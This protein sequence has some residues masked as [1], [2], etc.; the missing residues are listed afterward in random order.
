[1][2]GYFRGYYPGYSCDIQS[3]KAADGQRRMNHGRFTW[4]ILKGRTR[5]RNGYVRLARKGTNGKPT[6]D[7]L[8]RPEINFKYFDKDDPEGSSKDRGAVVEGLRFA[9]RLLDPRLRIIWPP[10]EIFDDQTNKK[11]SEFV[12]SN[13]WGHHA[14]GT[15]AMGVDKWAVLDGD[16]RVRGVKNLRVV[17]AS[18]FPRIPGFFI[19]MSIYMISEKA[20]DVILRERRA[21]DRNEAVGPWPEPISG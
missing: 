13:S 10:Q 5:G 2:P 15:C 12:E 8:V 16:F 11:L 14:C 17:D 6:A 9:Q 20:S 21:A 19:I 18:V 3:E 1:L 7:P 4:A